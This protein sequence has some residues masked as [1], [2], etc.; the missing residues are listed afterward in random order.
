[1][2]NIL[3]GFSEVWRK[4]GKFSLCYVVFSM[5]NVCVDSAVTRR[6]TFGGEA[7]AML[8]FPSGLV[9]MGDGTEITLRLILPARFLTVIWNTDVHQ[10]GDYG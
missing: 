6:E 2:K 1:M 9:G 3:E 4:S 10:L 7:L 5:C 8:G